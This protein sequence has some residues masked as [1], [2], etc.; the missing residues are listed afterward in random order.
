VDRRSISLA[1]VTLTISSGISGACGSTPTVT[2]DV[3][4]PRP[5]GT[6]NR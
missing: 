3:S 5:L 6:S 4:N 1:A 2:F